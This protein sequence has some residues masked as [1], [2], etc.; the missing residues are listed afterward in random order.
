M[1]QQNNKK[2]N[3]HESKLY[4]LA[5]FKGV[6]DSAGAGTGNTA[7]QANTSKERQEGK[8]Q[9]ANRPPSKKVNTQAGI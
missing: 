2:R 8:K 7:T 6:A 9:A 1:R 5:F 4:N 3:A